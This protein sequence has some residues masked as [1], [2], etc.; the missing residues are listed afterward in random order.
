MQRRLKKPLQFSFI[1]TTPEDIRTRL[2]LQIT[3]CNSVMKSAEL[4][5]FN[6]QREKLF[7]EVTLSCL[8]AGGEST[9][10]PSL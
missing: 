9:K 4:S 10:C 8:T 3:A 6:A 7:T 1:M 2:E 5:S